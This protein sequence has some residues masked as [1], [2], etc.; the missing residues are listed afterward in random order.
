MERAFLWGGCCLVLGRF[1]T[2]VEWFCIHF[3]CEVEVATLKKSG[4]KHYGLASSLTSFGFASSND[5]FCLRR[6]IRQVTSDGMR[7]QPCPDLAELCWHQ[8]G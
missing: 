8:A 2:E 4:V 6:L 1:L 3:C 7:A 5:L